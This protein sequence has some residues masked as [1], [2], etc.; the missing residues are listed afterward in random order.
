MNTRRGMRAYSSR[1][2]HDPPERLMNRSASAQ[3][4]GRPRRGGRDGS[5]RNSRSSSSC[6]DRMVRGRCGYAAC[7]TTDPAIRVFCSGVVDALARVLDVQHF[8]AERAKPKEVAS[9][10]T[11]TPPK[12]YRAM[13]P[14]KTIFTPAPSSARQS[15]RARRAIGRWRDGH[16]SADTARAT[17]GGR[18]ASPCATSRPSSRTR[19]RV[20]SRIVESRW[21]ITIVVRSW[22]RRR[23]ASKTICSEI[24]SRTMS[25]HPESESARS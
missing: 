24:A 25:A 4:A 10:S 11:V 23:S 15:I 17:P 18:R 16:T 20:A 6:R 7:H 9:A 22:R 19:I 21:A 13:I 8:M 5:R 3:Y 14:A 2:N 1:Q 12:G